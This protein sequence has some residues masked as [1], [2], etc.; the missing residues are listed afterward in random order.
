MSD[1]PSV[2]MQ[3][4][5]E[6]LVRLSESQRLIEEAKG[7]Y[8][9]WYANESDEMP[10]KPEEVQMEFWR[11]LLYFQP[12]IRVQLKPYIA[13]ALKMVVQDQEFGYYRLITNLDGTVDDDYIGWGEPLF[14]QFPDDHGD[15]GTIEPID[16]SV[17]VPENM[18]DIFPRLS[19]LAK[20]Q[21]LLQQAEKRCTE[22]FQRH[23][24][25]FQQ[26][27]QSL[28]EKSNPNTKWFHDHP[29]WFQGYSAGLFPKVHEVRTGFDR[30]LL[31]FNHA[32]FPIPH[33]L[34]KLDVFAGGYE[35]GEYCLATDLKGT[36]IEGLSG[37]F[38]FPFSR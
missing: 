32:E 29:T 31:C 37:I 20:Q 34:T 13:T 2:A 25:C 19:H 23:P 27:P 21:E 26:Y 12:G 10:Y 30:Q 7:G 14:Y 11:Q 4:I 24:L 36:I 5:V 16:T 17:G 9:G 6:R 35:I 1:G 8:A 38:P 18:R 3:D 28:V 33:I 15:M 22:W